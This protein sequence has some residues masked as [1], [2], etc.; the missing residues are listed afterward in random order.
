MKTVQRS[1]LK[2]HI[3]RGSLFFVNTES[4]VDYLDQRGWLITP[5]ATS[6]IVDCWQPEGIYLPANFLD[7][8]K[9]RKEGFI[10]SIDLMK[11]RDVM[12]SWGLIG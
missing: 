4:C 8:M 12:V 2:S 7:G 11:Y 1:S 9:P 10:D 5:F 6:L 3:P